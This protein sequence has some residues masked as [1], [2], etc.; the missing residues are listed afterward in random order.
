MASDA[1]SLYHTESAKGCFWSTANVGEALPGV[2]TPFGWSVWGPAIDL[3][4]KDAFRRTGALEPDRVVFDAET[5]KRAVTVFHGRGALSVNFLCEMGNRL[6][7]T[8]SDAIAKQLLGEMPVGIQIPQTGKRHRAIA[9]NMPKTFANIRKEALRDTAHTQ[10]W[11]SSH[12]KAMPKRDMTA[13]KAALEDARKEMCAMTAIQA[14][15]VFVGVQ[16]IYDQLLALIAKSD[17][18]PE[19]AN[20][21]MAGQGSHAE[22]EIISDLWELGRHQQSLEAFLDKHG[23]HGLGEGQLIA[24]MWREDPEPVLRLAKQYAARPDSEHPHLMAEQR[25][26]EREAAEKALL[27]KTPA[28]QRPIAKL[29]LKLAVARIPLRGVAK[30]ALIRCLDVCRAAARR[31]GTL[32]VE[33]G[34]LTDPEDVFYFTADELIA[35]LP[36][37]A[38]EVAAQ[39]RAVR[40]ELLR[41]DIPRTWEGTPVPIVIAETQAAE[42]AADDVVQ[43]TGIGAS[44]GVVEGLVRVVHDPTEVD[45]EPGEIIVSQTTD[46]SW[47]AVLFLATALVV[48]IGGPLSHAAVVARECGIP[49]VIGTDNGTAVLRTGDLVRVDG[50]KGTVEIL[51]RAEVSA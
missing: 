7:G 6:P 26:R 37:N 20:A 50:N 15:A 10:A 42:G 22:T 29:I 51:K 17:I 11:W 31:M 40:E 5:D 47:A 27:A 21:L 28:Y 45:V 34:V 19:Q 14:R 38:P 8:S 39:R 32:L 36:A 49:C 35:G 25:T 48:D 43:V 13:T 3:G 18:T 23:Y 2:V 30:E 16:S 46:P 1:R 12:I 44:G 33:Q 4:M 41:L 9:A 24:K